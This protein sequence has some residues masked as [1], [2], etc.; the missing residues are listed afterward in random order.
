MYNKSRWKIVFS[1]MGSLVLLL[2]VT[3]SV[4]YLSSYEEMRRG[5]F[6]RLERYVNLFF[7]D[8]DDQA[9]EAPPF[10][11]R[12]DDRLSV[13]YSVAFSEDGEVLKV[14]NADKDVYGEEELVE[15]AQEIVASGRRTGQTGNLVYMVSYRPGYRLV[16]FLDNTLSKSSLDMLLNNV[17]ITGACA[18][19]ALFV[20]SYFLSGW[21]IRPLEENNRQQKQ[22]ISDASHELKT[23]VSAI[24]ANAE[25]LAREIGEN[26]W[27]SNIRYENGRMGELITQLLNLSRA[28]SAQ[29]P[30]EKLDLSRLVT[31][32][33]FAMESLAYE[34]GK[35]IVC[36]CE[37]GVEITGNTAR[38][39][40]LVSVLVDNA[41]KHSTG[42]EIVLT[43]KRRSRNAVICVENEGNAIPADR[44]DHIFDRFYRLDEAR[45]GETGH[46][47]LGLSIAK[48][49]VLRHKGR[50]DVSCR[51]GKVV[52]TVSLP[53]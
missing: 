15:L 33:V 18:I 9:P 4:I 52:F 27:L 3:L 19:V 22:F 48:A 23:P 38:L 29:L 20:I 25:V 40:Q 35:T 28:E 2:G 36:N 39:Q 11:M 8:Q 44:L 51:D 17:L 43:L 24:G 32:E 50:I 16:G 30:M 21:I 1:I 37:D 34:N 45:S 41:I 26:E 42:K 6:E 5:N 31:G 7:L 47:G 49:V 12:P 14:D 46:Y 53:A 10:E 13:F